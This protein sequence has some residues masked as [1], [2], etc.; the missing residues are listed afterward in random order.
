MQVLL[1][2][3]SGDERVW[4]GCA[5]GRGGPYIRLEDKDGVKVFSKP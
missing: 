4:L 3:G 1:N 5:I 2:S